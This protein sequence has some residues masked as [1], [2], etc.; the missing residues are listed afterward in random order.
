MS[1]NHV[2]RTQERRPADQR[3]FIGPAGAVFVPHPLVD[4]TTIASKVESG[5]WSELLPESSKPAKKAAAKP[6]SK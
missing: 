2:G 5:E 1:G 6:S 4:E 3:R